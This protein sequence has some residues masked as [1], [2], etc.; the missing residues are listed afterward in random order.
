[1]QNEMD[2]RNADSFRA[3]LD[4]YNFWP[5]AARVDNVFGDRNSVCS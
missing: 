3:D 1:M 5:H 2:P 4:D